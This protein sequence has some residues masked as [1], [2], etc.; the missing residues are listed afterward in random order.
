MAHS[1]W[2]TRCS[3]CQVAGQSLSVFVRLFVGTDAWPLQQ[4][5]T[6]GSDVERLEGAVNE[7]SISKQDEHFEDHADVCF[8]VA[9]EKFRCHR[10]VLAARSEYFKARFSR[11]TE[12]S[13]GVASREVDS[14]A[15]SLPVLQEYDLSAT[16]FE[17]VLEYM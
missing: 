10:F 16:A 9:N 15:D 13:E 1:I 3:Y 17:K 7:C 2:C 6:M 11:T 8:L 4:D 14:G 5:T 12:F